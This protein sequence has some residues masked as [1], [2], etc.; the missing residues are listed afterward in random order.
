[1]SWHRT[2]TNFSIELY[3]SPHLRSYPSAPCSNDQCRVS[4][5]Q[6]YSRRIGRR[7][8]GTNALKFGRNLESLRGRSCEKN[9]ISCRNWL[10]STTRSSR[11]FDLLGAFLVPGRSLHEPRYRR[12]L[13][14]QKYRI[15]PDAP[16]PIATLLS[17]LRQLF[18]VFGDS[19][20][21]HLKSLADL[22]DKK[23]QEIEKTHAL[24]LNLLTTFNNAV[25]AA[26]VKIDG[27]ND[28]D[29][30]ASDI[31]VAIR[32]INELRDANREWRRSE[33]EEARIY[34]ENP[35]I[36]KASFVKKVPREVE[37]EVQKF[38][39]AYCD[40][41][42]FEGAYHHSSGHVAAMA[43]E[44]IGAYQHF[45]KKGEVAA[46]QL[47]KSF[48]LERLG[49]VLVESQDAKEIVRTRWTKFASAYHH[50]NHRLR[51]YGLIRS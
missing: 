51:E 13:N 24:F 9:S 25:G 3:L 27:S 26:R 39:A 23:F 6:A 44:T 31:E 8:N 42:E 37:N 5:P 18:N 4:R 1:M 14:R 2:E 20:K 7:K 28:I 11:Q 30:I 45:G 48:L 22:A 16:I 49:G 36:D 12:R 29:S 41:F 21:S 17:L 10:F 19:G 43:G 34:R 50:L 46:H 47:R 32:A 15:M 33:Y 38:M 40:Y 35:I